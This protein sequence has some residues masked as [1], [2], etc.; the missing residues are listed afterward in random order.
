M[1]RA[2]SNR[3]A[4]KYSGMEG[5]VSGVIAI[6]TCCRKVKFSCR[7]AAM[8]SGGRAGKLAKAQT[9]L[10]SGKGD[11]RQRGVEQPDAVVEARRHEQ[12][13]DDVGVEVANASAS[14]GV[15]RE[16]PPDGVADG[17]SHAAA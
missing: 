10:S 1:T 3:S 2:I 17:P 15:A 16:R 7:F 12:L 9:G 8:H 13:L 5:P 4:H 11:L 6:E 14:G